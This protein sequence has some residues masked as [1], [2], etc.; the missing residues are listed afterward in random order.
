MPVQK[1]RTA[2]PL[3]VGLEASGLEV[4]QGGVECAACARLPRPARPADGPHVAQR[5]HADVREAH[6][7][8]SL[9]PAA[10]HQP[11]GPRVGV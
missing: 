1:G 4:A 8:I 5:I 2:R 6:E 9:L 3:A 11:H 10:L 7:H